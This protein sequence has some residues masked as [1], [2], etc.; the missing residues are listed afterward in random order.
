MDTIL[1]TGHTWFLESYTQEPYGDLVIRLV[2]GFKG[3][4]PEPVVV[5]DK[6]L[7]PYFPVTI[8]PHSRCVAVTFSDLRGLL[9]YS[10]SYDANDPTLS[11]EQ[12]RFLRKASGSSFRSFMEQ[13]STAIS[14]FRGEF[15]EFLL[16][17]ED[18]IFQVFAGTE[19]S[20]VVEDRTPNFALERGRTWAAS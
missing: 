10:E 20:V 12:G 13:T 14:D 17:S 11:L 4:I 8:E 19:P 5:A 2:E 6:V 18:Q 1:A 9:T 15:F 7:G 16:W 3:S